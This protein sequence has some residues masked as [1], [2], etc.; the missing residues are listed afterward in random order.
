MSTNTDEWEQVENELD[1]RLANPT[2]AVFHPL[3]ERFRQ[4]ASTRAFPVIF[5]RPFIAAVEQMQAQLP[6]S[7]VGQMLDAASKLKFS[8][9]NP[10]WDVNTVNQ[11][12]TIFQTI[13]NQ[14]RPE[15]KPAEPEP[16][17]VPVVL[18]AMTS[19]QVEQLLDK[20]AFDTYPESFKDNF[21][22]LCEELK[23]KGLPDWRDWY[24]ANIE[25]WHPNGRVHSIAQLLQNALT[26]LEKGEHYPTRLVP[27]FYGILEVSSN[28]AMLRELRKK[29]CVVIVDSLSLRHPAMLRAFQRS[30]LDAYHNVSV[31]A[32]APISNGWNLFR[33]MTFVLQFHLTEMEFYRRQ[34]DIL[35][36]GCEELTEIDG[37]PKK[38]LSQV[39]RWLISTGT[40][41]S[42]L[43]KV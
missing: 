1:Q 26:E 22:R 2:M 28:W 36:E 39:R 40:Q 32:I 37:F 3:L 10:G 19:P 18:V 14:V 5:F 34:Q 23:D 29:G 33:E 43:P 41:P 6:Q 7:S 9:Q 21:Q 24:A 42:S 35:D 38:F 4:V 12:H 16:I 20:T 11:A 17:R 8:F 30:L 13:V 25:E 15:I 31:L 27:E